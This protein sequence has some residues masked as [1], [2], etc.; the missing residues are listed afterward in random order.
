MMDTGLIRTWIP[1]SLVDEGSVDKDGQTGTIYRMVR[2][3][4]ADS[5]ME[6]MISSPDTSDMLELIA[7]HRFYDDEMLNRIEEVS[8]ELAKVQESGVRNLPLAL[9]QS[10]QILASLGLLVAMALKKQ[11]IDQGRRTIAEKN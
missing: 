2:R 9:E 3:K 5:M 1:W 8:F 7:L 4:R 11:A 10:T 6:L